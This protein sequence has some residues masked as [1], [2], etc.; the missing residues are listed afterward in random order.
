[1]CGKTT[2]KNSSSYCAGFTSLSGLHL[3]I[4]KSLSVSNLTVQDK[5][6]REAQ[7]LGLFRSA[8]IMTLG[9]SQVKCVKYSFKKAFRADL[10]HIQRGCGILVKTLVKILV[11]QTAKILMF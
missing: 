1:M 3:D 11:S 2:G 5:H 8:A 9:R 7:Q 6:C 4:F 10:D